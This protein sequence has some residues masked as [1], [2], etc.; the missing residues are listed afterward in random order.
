MVNRLSSTNFRR[1]FVTNTAALLSSPVVGSS[2]NK[3][4]HRVKV[5]LIP[6]VYADPFDSIYSLDS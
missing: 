2:T 4:F 3:N 1:L 6:T 5:H